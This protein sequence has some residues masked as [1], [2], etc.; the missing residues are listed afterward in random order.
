MIPRTVFPRKCQFC[1][2]HTDFGYFAQIIPPPP[3][4]TQV[5]P[6]KEPLDDT[7]PYTR[8]EHASDLWQ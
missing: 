6:I 3:P 1:N 8:F 7:A 2:F 5:D 4:P